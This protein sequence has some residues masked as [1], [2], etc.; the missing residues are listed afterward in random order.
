M[1]STLLVLTFRTYS[2]SRHT[3]R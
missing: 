1:I 3:K 2:K